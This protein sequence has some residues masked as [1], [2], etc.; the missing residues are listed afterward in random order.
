M[1]INICVVCGQEIIN[2]TQYYKRKTC[3]KECKHK[4]M[5]KISSL[6][7]KGRCISGIPYPK[8][9]SIGSHE[10]Y[11]VTYQRRKASQHDVN[12]NTKIVNEELKQYINND[13]F[14]YIQGV[15]MGDGF[16]DDTK[17]RFRVILEAT[18]KDFV[19]YFA[20]SLKKV[21]I[22]NSRI[23]RKERMLNNRN[24]RNLYGAKVFSKS[25]VLFCNKNENNILNFNE[26]LK[27][28]YDSEGNIGLKGRN[29]R[30]SISNTNALL[31]EKISTYLNSKGTKHYVY[32]Y[33]PKMFEKSKKPSYSLN[34]SNKKGVL[35]FYKNIGFRINRKQDKLE[36]WFI[37]NSDMLFH[38]T[39]Q[40]VG[41]PK[42][43]QD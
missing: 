24:W 18:D 34:I 10:Y 32:K 23:I 40:V 39:Q 35:W 19:D 16:I 36:N 26:F 20:E 11:K 42:D 9:I 43:T 13:N 6:A 25:F 21:G 29:C 38:H 3:S 33:I 27:G 1:L 15:I 30:I 2:K 14:S 17:G 37:V 12:W 4:L 5:S 8:G 22:D 41:H 7:L 28:F 31:I